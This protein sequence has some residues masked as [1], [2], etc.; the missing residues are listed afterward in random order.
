MTERS[1][2]RKAPGKRRVQ[3]PMIVRDVTLTVLAAICFTAGGYLAIELIRRYGE[4]L[5]CVW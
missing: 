3:I 5:L 4:W 1:R 2:M